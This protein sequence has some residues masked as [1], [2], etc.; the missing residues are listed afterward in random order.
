MAG[1]R[2]ISSTQ[3]VA[4]HFRISIQPHTSR[5]SRSTPQRSRCWKRTTTDSNRSQ[6]DDSDLDNGE[7][8]E[9]KENRPPPATLKTTKGRYTFKLPSSTSNTKRSSNPF[10]SLRNAND[11][12]VHL[13]SQNPLINLVKKTVK[14]V[15]LTSVHK[16]QT[17]LWAQSLLN[18]G[19][20]VGWN[21]YPHIYK[22]YEK[23][24]LKHADRTCYI[25]PLMAKDEFYGAEQQKPGKHRIVFTKEGDY[26][27]VIKHDE[28]REGKF[29]LVTK[30]L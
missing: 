11:K 6:H 10:S 17:M 3:P 28:A 8:D 30:H 29:R 18:A 21:S 27:G 5:I 7:I 23:L 16:T 4:Q 22:N 12:A 24:S 15:C 1:S 13:I 2:W 25:F 19:K 9:D 14:A 26:A 20:S